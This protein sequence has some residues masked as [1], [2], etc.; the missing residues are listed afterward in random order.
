MGTLKGYVL[1]SIRS[2]PHKVDQ[3]LKSNILVK[4][5]RRACLVGFSLLTTIPDKLV[6]GPSDPPSDTTQWMYSIQWAAPE[7]LKGEISSKETDV[8]AFAMVIIE[9]H[10]RWSTMCEFL[11][12]VISFRCRYSAGQLR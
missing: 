1:Y 8:F 10:H 11:L 5:D 2:I 7:I 12:T 4:D 3:P 6:V 9:V